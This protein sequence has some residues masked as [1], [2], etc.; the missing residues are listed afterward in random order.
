SADGRVSLR[1]HLLALDPRSRPRCR[2]R[3][4]DRD[5]D[6]LHEPRA[7]SRPGAMLDGLQGYGPGRLAIGDRLPEPHP[8]EILPPAQAPRLRT[9]DGCP[10]ITTRSTVTRP[11]HARIRA[12]GQER[13]MARASF[14]PGKGTYRVPQNCLL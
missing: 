10:D 2:D 11:L 7:L 8:A 14:A 13:D 9:G 3:P 1:P 12:A 4:K 5:R 6:R